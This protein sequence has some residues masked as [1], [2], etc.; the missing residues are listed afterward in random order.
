MIYHVHYVILTLSLSLLDHLLNEQFP[1]A[2]VLDKELDYSE[3]YGSSCNTDLL[4]N[5]VCLCRLRHI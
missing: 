5:S 4:K 3:P 2:P 1:H